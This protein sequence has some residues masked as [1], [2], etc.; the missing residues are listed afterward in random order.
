M[1]FSRIYKNART[2]V[3]AEPLVMESLWEP[4]K[5]NET[6]QGLQEHPHE[7]KVGDNI[8]ALEKEAYEIGFN[9][10][11]RAGFELGKQKAEVAFN[12]LGKILEELTAFRENLYKSCEKE[13]VE[14]AIAIS[15]KVIQREVQIKKD[16]VL[17][18]VRAAMKA[19]MASGEIV[20]RVN[21]KDLDII[22]QYK[23][24]LVRYGNG[25]KG[26]VVCGDEA[27]ARG[28]CIVETNYGEVD[29]TLDS[30]MSEIEEKLKNAY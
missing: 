15:R 3:N 4:A 7:K 8:L 12:G 21:T 30:V 19:V 18:C 29:A 22:S 24:E 13:M 26:V 20:I 14:L 11:E 5:E 27:I 28:G 23:D 9:A 25:V 2:K 17:D 6:P 16:G 1:S 10:G